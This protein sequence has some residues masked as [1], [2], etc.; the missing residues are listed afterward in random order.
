MQRRLS[1]MT[2]VKLEKRGRIQW[3]K[4]IL[5]IQEVD[6]TKGKRYYR[7]GSCPVVLDQDFAKATTFLFPG[8]R[9]TP[10]YEALDNTHIP[11][12]TKRRLQ[13]LATNSDMSS[14]LETDDVSA[15]KRFHDNGVPQVIQ[16]TKPLF[17]GIHDEEAMS[18]YRYTGQR[19]R[20]KRGPLSE[21]ASS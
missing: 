9:E 14:R 7:V 16:T 5:G 11:Q 10:E 20:R 21:S 8:F 18:S 1:R 2:C 3:A 13:R 6:P 4:T 19:L 15:L 12:D 17:R